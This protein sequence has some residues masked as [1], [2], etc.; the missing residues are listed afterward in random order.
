M[1]SVADIPKEAGVSPKGK[2]QILNNE[3]G[4]IG[5]DPDAPAPQAPNGAGQGAIATDGD[6]EKY[7][8]GESNVITDW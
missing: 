4:S 6:G 7:D 3:G 8:K 1:A 2:P 5:A